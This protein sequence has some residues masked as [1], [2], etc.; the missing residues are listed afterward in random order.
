[1]PQVRVPTGCQYSAY[2]PALLGCSSSDECC[3]RKRSND[4]NPGLETS[5]ETPEIGHFLPQSRLY[6][7]FGLRVGADVGLEK[8]TTYARRFVVNHGRRS[9]IERRQSIVGGCLTVSQ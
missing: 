5:A 4:P 9:G 2:K 7:P 1:M 3:P 8:S 6:S